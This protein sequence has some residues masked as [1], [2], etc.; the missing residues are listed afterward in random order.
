MALEKKSI[1]TCKHLQLHFSRFG[2]NWVMPNRVVDLFAC[3]WMGGRSQSATIPL[4]L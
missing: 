3:W 2:L 1:W 4:C